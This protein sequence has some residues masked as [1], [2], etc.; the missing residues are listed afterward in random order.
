MNSRG[1]FAFFGIQ[2][3]EEGIM[4]TVR[5]ATA[6]FTH[7]AHISDF[8]ERCLNF[9]KTAQEINTRNEHVCVSSM[10]RIASA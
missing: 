7:V 4:Y 10:S 1:S 3:K 5:H 8:V 2:Y 9:F 6:D